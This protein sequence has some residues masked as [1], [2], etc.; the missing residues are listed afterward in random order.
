MSASSASILRPSAICLACA[1]PVAHT[2]RSRSAGVAFF[3]S[4]RVATSS[5]VRIRP[6]ALSRTAVTAFRPE[7]S[8]P[9]RSI[10]ALA[11][12]RF[13]FASFTTVA[14]STRPVTVPSVMVLPAASIGG[15]GGGTS[16]RSLRGGERSGD[17]DRAP[18]RLGGDRSPASSSSLSCPRLRG[19]DRSPSSSLS[20]LPRLGGDR[21]PS[22]SLSCLPFRGGDKSPSSSL[23]CRPGLGGERSSSLSCRPGLGGERSPSSSLSCLP[24]LGGERSPSDASPPVPFASASSSAIAQPDPSSLMP[25]YRLALPLLTPGSSPPTTNGPSSSRARRSASRSAAYFQSST[26]SS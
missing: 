4:S 25:R 15:G 11:A 17:G 23:S 3:A 7:V 18:R 8:S 12:A 21:S 19:G 10:L 6:V 22:S 2:G 1:T 5:A 13:S 9:K 14:A 24:G 16:V 20:C 26:S